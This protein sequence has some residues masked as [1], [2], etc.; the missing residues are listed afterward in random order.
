MSAFST[1]GLPGSLF[2]RSRYTILY[3]T[4]SNRCTGPSSL[5]VI[6][7][8]PLFAAA[9]EGKIADAAAKKAFDYWCNSSSIGTW[10]ALP[11]GTPAAAVDAYRT[12]FGKLATDPAFLEQGRSLFQDFSWVSHESLTA[13]VR[14]NEQVSPEVI[15]IMPQMLRRQGLEVN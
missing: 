4:G 11:P 8:V 2:D 15:G 12:A 7:G 3:Q 1:S 9:M 6:A 5:P 13:A 10:M 14:S